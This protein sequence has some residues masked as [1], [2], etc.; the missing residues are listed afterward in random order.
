MS[1]ILFWDNVYTGESLAVRCYLDDDPVVVSDLS[2]HD[3]W[4]VVGDYPEDRR[5]CRLCADVAS[6]ADVSV[7]DLCVR[8]VADNL[9]WV[10]NA[11]VQPT[12]SNYRVILKSPSN[13]TQGACIRNWRRRRNGQNATTDAISIL[14]LRALCWMAL[15]AVHTIITVDEE[16]T[17]TTAITWRF[18]N[19]YN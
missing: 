3:W 14:A 13:A 19:M 11:T 2:S 4:A 10:Y 9:R 18:S 15:H 5:C 7:A 16:K 12:V 1:A 17:S 6:H 8:L